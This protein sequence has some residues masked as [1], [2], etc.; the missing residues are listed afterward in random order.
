MAR[1]SK[2]N[3]VLIK[4]EYIGK[5][6]MSL[7]DIAKK[8][9]IS[10]SRVTK[11][12][13]KEG[14][15]EEKKRIWGEAEKEA[16]VETEGSIKDLIKRH[17]KV[18][19]YLQAGGIKNLKLIL[20]EVEDTLKTGSKDDARQLIK[21]LIFNKIISASTLT[22]MI[23]EGLKAERELYPKQMQIEGDLDVKFGEVS[24]ELKK[25]AHEALIKIVTEKPR[26]A[27]KHS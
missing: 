20:D 15:I 24:D 23:A 17:S 1:T 13:M 3:W 21:S 27:N 9:P 18:A 26:K 7:T 4:Q 19:R 11:V 2:V 14:W 5:K 16:L 12:S 22:A 6:E 25:A 10:Y 8:Y